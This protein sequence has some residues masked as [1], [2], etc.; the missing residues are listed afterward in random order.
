MGVESDGTLFPEKK[1]IFSSSE[2]VI[3]RFAAKSSLKAK[4]LGDFTG[5]GLTDSKNSSGN[6]I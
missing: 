6:P 2:S 5:V 4:R 3:L 1:S